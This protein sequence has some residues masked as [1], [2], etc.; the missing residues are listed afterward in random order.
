MRELTYIRAIQEALVEEM[1]RDEKV[2]LL[3]ESV[4]G[5]N[6][7]H[8]VGLVQKFGPE[9][10]LDTP[11]CE[12]AMSGA[13]HVEGTVVGVLADSLLRRTAEARYR[14]HIMSGDLTL[15]SPFHPEAESRAGHA[16]GRN[17]CVYC[18]SDAAVVVC[19][20]P[21]GGT[22][23]GATENLRRGWVPLWVRRDPSAASGTAGLFAQGAGRL[24]DDVE[25]IDFTAL[26]RGRAEA[27]HPPADL[28]PEPAGTAGEEP[29]RYLAPEEDPGQ[30]DLFGGAFR[31]RGGDS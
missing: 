29:V 25:G 26:V 19:S 31:E 7:E 17:R 16:T 12:T 3:G 10:V 4:R 23:S 21:E 27:E 28:P 30:M 8:T 11:I 2:F 6:F 13:L 18:L 5:G 1:Q 9:R 22:W 15:V 20:G 24:P 14:P